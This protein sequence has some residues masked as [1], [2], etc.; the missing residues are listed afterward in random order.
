MASMGP[1]SGR[2]DMMDSRV[3][4]RTPNWTGIGESSSEVRARRGRGSRAGAPG[5]GAPAAD[6]WL[7]VAGRPHDGAPHVRRRTVVEPQPFLGLAE[8]PADH[9]RELLQLDLHVRVEG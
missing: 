2:P 3:G 7:Q 9:V 4:S 6:R 8:M 1:V 5:S